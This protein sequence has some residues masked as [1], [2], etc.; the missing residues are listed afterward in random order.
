MNSS[1]RGTS[2]SLVMR[3]ALL[4]AILALPVVVLAADQTEVPNCV[5]VS[6]EAPYQAYGHT[7]IVVVRNGCDARI[8]CRVS[9]NVDPEPVR[10]TVAPGETSRT[11]TRR[12]SPSR[13][14]DARVTCTQD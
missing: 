12:G 1:N 4:F 3:S 2:I 8:Q 6:K 7:H 5:E 9:T 11:A 10:V 13:E 14:F